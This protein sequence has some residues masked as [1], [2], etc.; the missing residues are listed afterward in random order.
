MNVLPM[1]VGARAKVH[2]HDGIETIS[3]MLDGACVVHYGERLEHQ[4]LVKQGR[5][6]LYPG[7]RCAR[8]IER[9]RRAVHLDRGP[10][11]GQ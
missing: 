4:V 2:Y 10:L 1:P 11:V 5:A 8:A 3:Y 7:R 9:R 6:D